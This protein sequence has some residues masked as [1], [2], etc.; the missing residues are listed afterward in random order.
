M[1]WFYLSWYF[2]VYLS[3]IK[4][5]LKIFL[6]YFYLSYFFF[7]YSSFCKAV[8]V[9]YL[10]LLIIA[11]RYLVSMF[12]FREW[13][14]TFTS[15]SC[16]FLTFHCFVHDQKITFLCITIIVHF[17]EN[18]FFF[19]RKTNVE[20]RKSVCAT[21]WLLANIWE[22][23]LRVLPRHDLTILILRRWVRALL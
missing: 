19:R 12:A 18:I 7:C 9:L 21:Q 22:L 3:I 2:K 15:V 1:Y 17:N 23:S 8:I 4:I 10:M 11:K 20:N 14:F 5:I 13:E 16:T 6:S